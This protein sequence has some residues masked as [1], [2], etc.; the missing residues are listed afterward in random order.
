MEKTFK[1]KTTGELAELIQFNTN[2]YKV[3]NGGEVIPKRLI[4]NS[5]DW[6]EVFEKDYEILS[7]T[8]LKKDRIISFGGIRVI[9]KKPVCDVDSY[10]HQGSCMDNGDWGIYSVKY[11][12]TG[13]VFT[14]GDK[15]TYKLDDNKEETIKGII[16]KQGHI[17]LQ[18]DLKNPTYGVTLEYA[19]KVKSVLF[20]SFDDYSIFEG[21]K[22]YVPQRNDKGELKGSI[23]EIEAAKYTNLNDAS[24]RFAKKEN[25][26]IYLKTYKNY[27]TADGEQ[28]VEGQTFY[29]Y[30]DRNFKCIET[31]FGN[32]LDEKWAGK[33]FKTK[34]EVEELIRLN[35]KRFSLA[36]VKEAL[37]GF[38]FTTRENVIKNLDNGV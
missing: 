8:F 4:E 13:E 31:R 26:E 10:L 14:I 12:P 17:W 37:M 5:C 7:F 22:Y 33:R 25:A 36:D 2:F 3:S 18:K 6:E 9:S 20:Q 29:V 24:K 15:Y 28:V 35:Q 32:F 34:T 19:E 30:E 1:H 38:E 23:L 16:I 27:K 21:D 11:L